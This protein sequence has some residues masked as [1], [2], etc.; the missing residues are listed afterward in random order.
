M[1]VK[2]VTY[3]NAAETTELGAMGT[4]A[5]IPQFLHANETPENLSNALKTVKRCQSSPD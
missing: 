2:R 1:H 3:P 4:Q 5:C